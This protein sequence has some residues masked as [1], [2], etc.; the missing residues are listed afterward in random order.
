MKYILGLLFVMSL[1]ACKMS[2]DGGGLPDAPPQPP[3]KPTVQGPDMTGAW[4]SACHLDL[5][6][7]RRIL[8]LEFKLASYKRTESFFKDSQCLVPGRSIMNSGSF[9]FIGNLGNGD[10]IAEYQTASGPKEEKYK[11]VG[12]LLY[13]N[14]MVDS[15]GVDIAV[16]LARKK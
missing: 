7:E 12:D 15:R 3:S 8:K 9:R 4:T 13:V 2:V 5:N 16:P 10:W 1:S 11:I 14:N 6:N